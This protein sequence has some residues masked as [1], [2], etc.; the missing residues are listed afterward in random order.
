VAALALVTFGG[1]TE[2]GSVLY[3][4]APPKARQVQSHVIIAGIIMLY[5]ANGNKA[6]GA[7]FG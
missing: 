4:V 6:L 5:V 1:T 7:L 3:F 2:M